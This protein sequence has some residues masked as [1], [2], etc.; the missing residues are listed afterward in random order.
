M[1]VSKDV[2][3]N[4]RR[5]AVDEMRY[6]SIWDNAAMTQTCAG[7]MADVWLYIAT[8][9]RARSTVQHIEGNLALAR[10]MMAT[11]ADSSLSRTLQT[12]RC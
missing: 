4:V 7:P 8:H 2:V 3:D 9:C 5:W 1:P 6:S 11:G 10:H 12:D